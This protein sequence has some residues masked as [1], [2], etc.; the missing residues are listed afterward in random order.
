MR[1]S[2]TASLFTLSLRCVR[3]FLSIFQFLFLWLSFLLLSLYQLLFSVFVPL[4]LCTCDALLRLGSAEAEPHCG[5]RQ[6]TLTV[7]GGEGN[8]PFA[9]LMY[10]LLSFSFSR[11]SYPRLPPSLKLLSSM[12]IASIGM[13]SSRTNRRTPLSPFADVLYPPLVCWREAGGSLSLSLA[14]F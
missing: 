11:V 13:F 7:E 8:S 10:A 9:C 14:L 3:F 2:V 12:S 6:P 4:R 1:V 5:S